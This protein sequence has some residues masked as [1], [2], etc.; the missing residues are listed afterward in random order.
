MMKRVIVLVA[1]VLILGLSFWAIQCAPGS[2]APQEKKGLSTLS[3]GTPTELK[4]PLKGFYRVG[5]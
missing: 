4:M 1:L 2:K 3:T 5:P